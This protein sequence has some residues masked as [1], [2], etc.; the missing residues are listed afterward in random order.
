MSSTVRVPAELYQ[1]L[2]EIRLLLESEHYSAAPSVQDLVS[3]AIERFIADWEKADEKSKL[4]EEL[5]DRR[6]AARSRMGKRKRN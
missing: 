6:Q 4:N 2:R 5:L 3:L 1:K